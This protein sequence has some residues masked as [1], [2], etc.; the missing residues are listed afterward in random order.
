MSVYVKDKEYIATAFI[1][2]ILEQPGIYI[3]VC[4]C[5]CVR[6]YVTLGELTW[7]NLP[8][9]AVSPIKYIIKLIRT[10]VVSLHKK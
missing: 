1:V 8:N 10:E 7:C 3:Y 2:C 5:A 6:V 4:V 9:H